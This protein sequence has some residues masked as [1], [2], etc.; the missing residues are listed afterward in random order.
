MVPGKDYIAILTKVRGRKRDH[1]GNIVG[2]PNNNPI[3]DTII[4]ELELIYGCVEE[5][6]VNNILENILEKVDDDGWDTG[7]I[8]DIVS[9]CSDPN[10]EI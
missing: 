3:I 6:L 2:N 1:C 7:L 8:S 10:V 9:F 4:Y 5:Y